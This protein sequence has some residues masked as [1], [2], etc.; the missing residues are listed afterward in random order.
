MCLTKGLSPSVLSVDK[1][2]HFF[3]TMQTATTNKGIKCARQGFLLLRLV[4]LLFFN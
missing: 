3:A 4:N 2:T 1:V